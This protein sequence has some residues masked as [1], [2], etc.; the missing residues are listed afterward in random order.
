MTRPGKRSTGVKLGSVA[1]KT[2]ALT[3]WPTR[4]S[5]GDELLSVYLSLFL[6]L[7]SLQ[8]GTVN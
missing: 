1:L 8:S 6:S 4:R 3:T 2:D 7:S 5:S